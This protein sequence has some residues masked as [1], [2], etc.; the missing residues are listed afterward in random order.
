MDLHYFLGLYVLPTKTSFF[1]L[2]YYFVGFY[3]VS[4]HRRPCMYIRNA[5]CREVTGVSFRMMIC[6]K[7]EDVGLP[8]FSFYYETQQDATLRCYSVPPP[9]APVHLQQ[10]R[11]IHRCVADILW[12]WFKG[13]GEEEGKVSFQSSQRKAA[14]FYFTVVFCASAH[15]PCTFTTKSD[16]TL[17][18]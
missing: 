12:W 6:E 7:Q 14:S 1:I 16:F 9:T 18:W 10:H 2:Y 3:I 8:V 15:G 13:Q 11:W 4:D 17:R 5:E